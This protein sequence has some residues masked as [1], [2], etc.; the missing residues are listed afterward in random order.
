MMNRDEI[1]AVYD[2]GPE[3]V[4]DLVEQLFG[5]IREQQAQIADLT[6][7]V[8]ELEDRLATDSHNSS[9]PPSSDVSK[10][11]TQSLRQPSGKKPG[12]QPG[13]AGHTLRPVATPDQIILHALAQCHV[14]GVELSAV[15]AVE[16]E[17]RQVFDLPPVKVEVTEHR[18]ETKLCPT[19]GATSVGDFPPGV[20]NLVQYGEGIKGLAVYLMNYHLVPYRRTREMLEDLLGQPVAEGTLQAALAQCGDELVETETRIKTGVQQSRQAHF[21]ETGL[22]IEGKR[23]WLH[24]ASTRQLTHYAP[25]S[26]RGHLATD[27]IGI[28]P[29]FRGRAMHDGYRSYLSYPCQHALCNAHHLRELTFLEEQ[30][31][32][33][34]A[35]SL[36]SLLLEIKCVVER[37]RVAGDTQLDHVRIKT[38]ERRYEKILRQG[39]ASQS[40]SPALATGRRGPKKQTKAKNLLDRLSRYR[41]ETLA[42][43]YDFDVAFD[44]NLAERDLRMMKVQQKISGCFR[45]TDGATTFCRIRSYL[46]TIRKQGHNVLF[47]LRNVFAGHPIVPVL[48]G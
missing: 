6:A 8:K 40:S 42:F 15:P 35:G 26:K 39:F 3:A 10:K 37:A 12:A 11:R 7:R 33:A 4:I 17:C 45:T 21:D 41:C 18:V 43:M 27:E 5:I 28:L 31:G 47:A 19:C 32:Q 14:C 13:H 34:W 1:K 29:G 24:V 23:H 22:Y 25:H 9:K 20:N 36:K 16:Y 48:I 2:R 38:F 44:N 30:L 46:S